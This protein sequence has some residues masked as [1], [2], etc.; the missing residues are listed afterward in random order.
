MQ[1]LPAHDGSNAKIHTTAPAVE[2]FSLSF[3]TLPTDVTTVKKANSILVL[4]SMTRVPSR[5]SAVVKIALTLRIPWKG[6]QAL[7][8]KAF[9]SPKTILR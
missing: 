3:C 4:L 2:V 7:K 6:P 5:P 8:K 1:W 9:K